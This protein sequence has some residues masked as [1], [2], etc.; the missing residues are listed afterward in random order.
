MEIIINY[1][2]ENL[3]EDFVGENRSQFS[4]R[5]RHDHAVGTATADSSATT[6]RYVVISDKFNHMEIKTALHDFSPQ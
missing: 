1:P 3:R 6:P 4:L 2:L 5:L